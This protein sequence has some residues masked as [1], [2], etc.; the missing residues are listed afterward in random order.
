MWRRVP[1]KV[2]VGI[3]LILL[4]AAIF[5]GW[6]WWMATRTWVPLEMPISLAKGHI[7]SREFRTNFDGS[8]WIW[9]EVETAVD[10]YGVSCL[11]GYNYDSEYCAKKNAH[12]LRATWSL[13][14]SQKVIA[15]G[16]TD[17]YPAYAYPIFGRDIETKARELGIFEAPAG[18]HYVLDID[19]VEDYSRFDGGHPHLAIVTRD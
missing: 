19:I 14:E 4:G 12:E 10:N 11:L 13:S 8:F 5:G 6:R 16:P 3:G 2:W 1:W 9:I 18:Q 7:R 15:H 17:R